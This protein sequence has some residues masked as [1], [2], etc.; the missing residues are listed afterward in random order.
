MNTSPRDPGSTTR[1][2]FLKTSSAALA[3]AALAGA[4]ARPGFAAEDHTLKLALVGCGGRGSGAVAQALSTQG[5]TKLWAAA[6]VFEHRVQSCLGAL[7]PNHEKQLAV[8]P[9]RQY[10]GLDAFKKAIDSL[11]KG[12]V[13]LLATPP[14]FRPIHFEYAVAK[15]LHVFMEKSFAVDAPGIRRVLKAGEAASKQNLKVAGGLMCRHYLPTEEVIDQIHAGAIGEV[16]TAWAYR[17]HG[18]VGLNPRQPGMN[19]L[20]YQISNYSNFTWLNGSF[21]EDWL[22]HNIDVCCWAKDGWPVSVQGMG[23]R[24]VRQDRDQLF[25]HYAAEYT[26]ADGTRMMAQAR[27]I[28]NC[29]DLF[30]DI[31]HGTKGSALLGE[32]QPKPRLFKSHR[33][34]SENLL[35]TYEG[36][37][38]DQY[39]REHD[40]LFDA[41]RNDKPY[42]ETERCAKSCLTAI[43]GRMACESGKQ[44]TWDEALASNLELAPGLEK[45]TWD[46]NPPAMPD[47]SGKYP[48]AVPGQTAG[49]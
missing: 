19:E 13:V 35:W 11:D 49:C 31:I 41:I 26:F 3:G 5:P 17:M 32:G 43:M 24:H 12:D 6:D 7:K 1:R 33:Q 47:G 36:P 16:I 29:W 48:V 10:I 25:D 22:I 38:C 46:S 23:G 27:H 14:A 45:F 34:T 9:E 2:E 44:I 15:G 37:D 28:N 8:P 42:N 18:A 4:I 20:A 39:Q 40:L 30:G 21:I